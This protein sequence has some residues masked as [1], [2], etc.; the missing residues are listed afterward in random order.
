M[1]VR[2]IVWDT[3]QRIAFKNFCWTTEAIKEWEEVWAALWKIGVM[4]E[5][6]N[7]DFYAR[8][9]G[10]IY[11]KYMVHNDAARLDMA[12]P[13]PGR[14]VILQVHDHLLDLPTDDPY[15]DLTTNLIRKWIKNYV[16]K[17]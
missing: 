8:Q 11:N 15:V 6:Q 7:G 1:T 5:W 16:S 3:T 2:E 4:W 14:E 12:T 10:D 13:L 17:G 9:Y